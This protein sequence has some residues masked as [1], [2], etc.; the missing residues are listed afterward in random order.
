MEV[1]CYG[2]ICTFDI[3]WNGLMQLSILI[4]FFKLYLLPSFVYYSKFVSTGYVHQCPVFWV[5]RHIDTLWWVYFS[6]ELKVN[7]PLDFSQVKIYKMALFIATFHIWW[8]WSST[9]AT[10]WCYQVICKKDIFIS[11]KAAFPLVSF[12]SL[13][14][15]SL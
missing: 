1:G 10:T 4:I 6:A 2:F 12:V 15:L 5:I 7:G 11:L 14:A 3:F 9:I 8:W 13:C